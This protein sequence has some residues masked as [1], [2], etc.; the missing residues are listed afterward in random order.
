[1]G[2]CKHM[3]IGKS[4]GVHCRKCGLHLTAQQ[5]HELLHPPAPQ[6]VEPK[7]ARKKKETVVNG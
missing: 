6:Q 5:Y 4:D 1:M 2:E 7:R 3:F